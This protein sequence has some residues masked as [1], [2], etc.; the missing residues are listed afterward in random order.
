[1]HAAPV[2][3]NASSTTKRVIRFS[4]RNT[5][6]CGTATSVTRRHR[7]ATVFKMAASPGAIVDRILR[8]VHH[9]VWSDFDR[10][11]R[12]LIAFGE[13][14]GD[15]GRATPFRHLPRSR[16]RRSVDARDL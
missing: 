15:G 4:D 6:R 8:P 12:K 2:N 10:R 13:V 7:Y 14:E 3:A 16:R 11:V 9:W 5:R 1:M